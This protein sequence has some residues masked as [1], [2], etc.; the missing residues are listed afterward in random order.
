MFAGDV[1]GLLFVPLCINCVLLIVLFARGVP[2]FSDKYRFYFIVFLFVI[3]FF[4]YIFIVFY[5]ILFS[6]AIPC[7]CCMVLLRPR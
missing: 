3:S 2:L 1:G 4:S 5:R 7:P 6:I